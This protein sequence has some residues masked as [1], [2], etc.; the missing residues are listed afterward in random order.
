MNTINI[1][2]I[3]GDLFLGVQC[4]GDYD[5]YDVDT[6]KLE[7]YVVDAWYVEEDPFGTMERHPDYGRKL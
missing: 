1:S 2:I 3:F 6:H 7:L 5:T 4:G